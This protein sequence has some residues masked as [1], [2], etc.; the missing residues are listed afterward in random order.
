[1]I[2]LENIFAFLGI[3][4]HEDLSEGAVLEGFDQNLS[5]FNPLVPLLKA[6][7]LCFSKLAA[8]KSHSAI[9]KWDFVNYLLI[10]LNSLSCEK[11]R[12]GL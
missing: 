3:D 2:S 4:D 8:L 12:L 9:S 7:L 10:G 11:V 5:W 6:Q 1:M